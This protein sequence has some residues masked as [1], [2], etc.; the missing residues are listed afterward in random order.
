MTAGTNSLILVNSPGHYTISANVTV[1][2]TGT[3]LANTDRAVVYLALRTYVGTGAAVRG[4]L[5]Y[6]YAVG[7]AYYRGAAFTSNYFNLGGSVTIY[8]DQDQVDAGFE[9]EVATVCMGSANATPVVAD[10]ASCSI[11]IERL[12]YRIL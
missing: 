11:R 4:T 5:D 10:R 1:L 12:T 9:M 3:T 7:T 2:D 8:V 6:E